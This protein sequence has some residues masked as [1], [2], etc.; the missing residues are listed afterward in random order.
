MPRVRLD[1][2]ATIKLNGSGA[3]TARVGPLSARE[4]WHPQ[5]VTVSAVVPGSSITN[6]AVCSIYIGDVTIQ[7]NLIEGTFTGSSGDSSDRISASTVKVGAYIWAMWSG[8]DA[9]AIA[10]VRVTGTKEV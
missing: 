5:I 6:E 3:G 10:T 8:G 4:V 1:E 9:N 2:S 7:R